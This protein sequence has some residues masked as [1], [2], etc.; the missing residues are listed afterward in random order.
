M[1]DEKS[2]TKLESKMGIIE[3]ELIDLKNKGRNNTRAGF[4]TGANGG[5]MS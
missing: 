4:I 3:S 2:I 5:I 1:R